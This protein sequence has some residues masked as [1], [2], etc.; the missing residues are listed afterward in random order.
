MA[1]NARTEEFQ[2]IEVFDKPALFTNGRIA[3]DTVPKGW[4]CYDIRGSDDDP[5][6]LCY[7]EENVVVNHA[8]SVLMPEKLAMPK[9]GRL[10]VRDELGF[11][12]EGNMTL[13][14][15]CE[16]HQLPYPA[17]NM[18][19]H[20]RPARPEEAGLFYTPHPEEDKRLGTVGHVRMDFGRSGNEFWHTWW[21]RGPEELNSP[22][23]KAELQE[24]VD[25]LR[26]SVLKNRFAMER[27][28]YAR[29]GKISG[30]WTQNY[31]YIVE[32][33]HYR[34]CLRCNLSPGDYN[35][36][37]TAYDLDVQRQNM[38]RDK[39]LV[40]RV[41]YANGDA[42]EFTDAEAFLKCV[43]EE[44][45]YRPTTGFRYEVLTD[46]SSV[47]RQVDD[48]IFDF[49]GEEAPCRQE[50]HEPRPEQG[51]D[52]RRNVMDAS[53]KQ[54]EPVAFKSLAE[55]KRFIRP[56][57]E[58][59]TVSHAN[60]AD[61]VGLT[62]VVTTVQTVGFYSKIK[63]Q[64]EHPFSTC[65]HGKGF[66]TDF[67]KAGKYI[68]DG[69]TVKVKDTRKQDRGVIYELE[70]YNREQNME[71][72]MMDRKMVNFIKEQYP[73]GTRIRLNSMEDPY[74]PILPGTEGEVD[75][76]D[77]AGQLHMKWDNGRS[78]ALIPGEDSF[79]VL[80]PKLTSL[81]LYM[82]LTADL[83]E[84]NEY[85]DF[86][87]SSTLLEGRELRGYQDQIT[88]ALV[89]N[90]MPE[91]A[92]R[93]L[94][95]WYDEADSVDRKVRSAVFAVEERNRQL[96]GVAECRVA[97][98]L[99]DTELEALKEYLTGQASDGWGEGFEQREISVDDGGELY[100]H[101]WNSDEWCI[102]T[103]QELF[104]PK[105]A[106]GL[107]ELCFSTLPGT[108]ELI[109]IKR[110]ESGYYPSDWST[111]DPAH[112]REIADYNNERLGVTPAQEKAMKTGSMFGWGVPG[113]DPACYEQKQEMGGM[114]LG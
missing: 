114:T 10:D 34:Y 15:F 101:F 39:P 71:E 36:Y 105:L 76:V 78:L 25:T 102:Q 75:Y 91:E 2:H 95:H 74:A 89:K 4:Y 83:Y 48:M 5:G 18:K 7:M 107:P 24:V 99:S 22:V 1:V 112:N 85:G 67:G 6:E 77:D 32:T 46:D 55:L 41:S 82:P 31:G 84:R 50:D 72:T 26:E 54:R 27:F 73:P 97:G 63:D 98:E 44:L 12:D 37:L 28:C 43:R 60:H 57:V 100:V 42:Q 29:G 11:L 80:P 40:G 94:M 23:F 111:N 113:A 30:G 106:D 8:G 96:W 87:D 49:Y 56:G 81:K 9:S 58:F 103:E 52:L 62:R 33:E 53:K 3:R 59:K 104:S 64:P 110:G 65:N 88:A 109:C 66:Y 17:E 92:E 47:R 13:C 14:E 19:F 20:I 108:G 45:P 90:R 38:A 68:F 79:S 61:M 93:G 16:A 51:H 70:F 35:G 21:P 69:T 86:D